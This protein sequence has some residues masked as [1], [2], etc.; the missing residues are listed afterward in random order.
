MMMPRDIN[1]TDC[2][3]PGIRKV[4]YG[5]HMCHFYKGPEDLVEALVPYFMA[6]LRNNERCLWITAEPLDAEAA[7]QALRLAGLSVDGAI[8]G[9]SL[10]VR[11]FSDWYAE[12]RDL[13]GS[14]VIDLWLEEERRALAD[15]HNGLRITG[16]VTFLTP[17]TWPTFMEY[18]ALFD[19][20]VAGRRIVALCTYLL[21]TSGA[22]DFLDVVRRHHCA[23]DR[24]DEGWQML[25]ERP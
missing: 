1:F 21:A 22:A 10:V 6:G 7:R 9:G 2:G 5:I 19:K 16:N 4:P 17:E 23:L 13:K 18:E 15:G 24:P 12:E 25:T 8:H 11:D 14:Q 3:L 20:A